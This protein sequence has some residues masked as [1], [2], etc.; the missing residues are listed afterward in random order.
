MDRGHLITPV[1]LDIRWKLA[2]KIKFPFGKI[3]YLRP[4]NIGVG[5]VKLLRDI[6]KK[7][8]L[9]QRPLPLGHQIKMRG[10][11]VIIEGVIEKGEETK[12][13]ILNIEGRKYWVELPEKEKVALLIPGGAGAY[14][15]AERK[16]HELK[17]RSFTFWEEADLERRAWFHGPDGIGSSVVTGEGGL[18]TRV[19]D[20]RF[21]D[22]GASWKDEDTGWVWSEHAGE[23]MDFEKATEF[24]KKRG[25]QLPSREMFEELVGKRGH[26]LFV[27]QNDLWWSS[28]RN[29]VS[30][31]YAWI[32]I[33]IRGRILFDSRFG[34]DFSVRCVAR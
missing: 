6:S 14:R 27:Q 1:S 28:S 12:E 23:R 3:E 26:K 11:S 34:D 29:R 31:N 17:L 5:D 33:G 32:F 19:D 21:R 10:T 16:S 22:L 24:C 25:G 13:V 4:N 9:G 20:G 15:S 18:F 2:K 7:N 30:P 8:I